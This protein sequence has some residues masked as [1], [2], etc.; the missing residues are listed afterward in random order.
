LVGFG[1]DL[2]EPLEAIT[3]D[4]L[5]LIEQRVDVA[6]GVDLSSNDPFATA[7]VFDDEVGALRDGDML[8]HRVETHRVAASEI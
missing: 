4:G 2:A 3:P 1:E 8:L 6:D 7:L 5:E